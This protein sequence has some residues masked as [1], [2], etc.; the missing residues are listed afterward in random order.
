MAAGKAGSNPS[1][2]ISSISMIPS[3]AA[4]AWAVPDM[5]AKI[6]EAR[7]FTCASPPFDVSHHRP[8]EI[9]N[10]AGDPGPAEDVARQDEKR[11]GQKGKLSRPEVIFCTMMTKWRAAVQKE[12]R[13]A[14]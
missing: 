10:A 11:K 5:P 13:E 7:T 1:R 4:S 2:F 6:I 3:P 12:V 14:R 9:K 8:G